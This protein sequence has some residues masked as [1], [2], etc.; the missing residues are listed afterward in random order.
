MDLR[1]IDFFLGELTVEYVSSESVRIMILGES[2]VSGASL[3]RH[4]DQGFLLGLRS[5]S[6][7][8]A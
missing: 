7:F 2:F 5:V 4:I 1:Y 3:P 8:Y 6:L